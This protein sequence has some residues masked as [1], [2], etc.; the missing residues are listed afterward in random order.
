MP[1]VLSSGGDD[2]EVPSGAVSRPALSAGAE[3]VPAPGPEAPAAG[4]P[5]GP[6]CVS[7][8]D[9][10]EHNAAGERRGRVHRGAVIRGWLLDL[11]LGVVLG[12]VILAIA[13]GVHP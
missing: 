3:A 9:H 13:A 8:D 2:A 11:V 4:M 1:R 10:D 7:G 12:F 5:E 6:Q